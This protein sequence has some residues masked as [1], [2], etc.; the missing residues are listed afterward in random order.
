MIEL[1]C[2]LVVPGG[3]RFTAVD[4]DYGALIDSQQHAVTV[5]GIDPQHVIIIAIRRALEGLKM[6]AAVSRAVRA[7]LH[8][9]NHIS[10]FGIDE[11]SAEI[12]VAND[13]RIVRDLAPVRARI[14]GAIESL[15][16][17]GENAA[18]MIAR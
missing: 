10:I 13:A 14:I 1:A 3:P 6:H 18:A 7:G 11:H 8:D 5:R 4:A 17:D 15:A 12:T 16:G 9:V 2:G